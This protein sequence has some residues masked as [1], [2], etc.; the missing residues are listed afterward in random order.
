MVFVMAAL[1]VEYHVVRDSFDRLVDAVKP[2]VNE[3]AVKV[4]TK[5]LIST[6]IKNCVENS[7]ESEYNRASRLLDQILNKIKENAA[8]FDTFIAILQD[9][10][11]LKGVADELDEVAVSSRQRV[12]ILCVTV[13]T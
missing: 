4:F 13:K 8:H 6:D 12:E 9:I 7:R 1:S 3:V 10:P 2:V 11:V 5:V